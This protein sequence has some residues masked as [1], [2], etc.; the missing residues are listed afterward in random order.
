MSQA[1]SR[2]YADGERGAIV[3]DGAD[4]IR[5]LAHAAWDLSVGALAGETA[6]AKNGLDLETDACR[7]AKEK[8]DGYG[9]LLASHED[10]RARTPGRYS[11]PIG[12][13]LV[14]AAL[15]LIVSDTPLSLSLVAGGLRLPAKARLLEDAGSKTATGDLFVREAFRKQTTAEAKRWENDAASGRVLTTA[16]LL[17]SPVSTVRLFW[18]TFALAI[19]LALL[20]IALKP[21]LDLIFDAPDEDHK[22]RWKALVLVSVAISLFLVTTTLLGYFRGKVFIGDAVASLEAEKAKLQLV[23]AQTDTTIAPE[24]WAEIDRRIA[25]ERANWL[26]TVAFIALTISLPLIGAVC[27]RSALSGM[28]R[29]GSPLC[30]SP[31]ISAHS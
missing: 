26:P 2:G 17:R 5:E 14:V 3:R 24:Q 15:L 7:Q 11:L 21:L 28:H 12:I 30:A 4:D 10:A 27:L 19:G 6:A 23:A 25:E 31:L 20:G 13:T 16:D 22:N 29:A 18:D 8:A 9:K 1:E